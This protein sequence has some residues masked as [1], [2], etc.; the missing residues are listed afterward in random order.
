MITKS[1]VELIGNTPLLDMSGMVGDDAQE[2]SLE[3]GVGNR[4]EFQT[5]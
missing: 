3:F 5:V 1:L 2:V 4:F